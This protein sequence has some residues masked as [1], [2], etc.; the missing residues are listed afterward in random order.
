MRDVWFD[1]GGV[2]CAAWHF[3]G[4]G[5]AFAAER[6]RPCVVMAHGI[7][8]TRD[9]GLRPFAERF[10]AAGL[11]AFVFDYRHFGDSGGEPRQ[12]VSVRR[13]HADYH[14]AIAH[15]RGLDGV[16]PDRIV[17]WGSSYAGGHVIAVAADD[18]RLAAAVSQVPA[19]DGLAALGELLRYAG[20]GQL[21]R[22]TAHGIRDAAG[23][24]LGRAPHTLPLVGPPGSLAAMT[25]EDAE[26]GYKAIVGPTWRNEIGARALLEVGLN[27]PL[28]R[29]PDVRCPL[30]VQIAITDTVAPPAAAEKAA[31]RAPR[32][33]VRHYPLGHFDVYTG[34][35]FERVVTD[36]VAFLTRHLGAPRVLAG[37]NGSGRARG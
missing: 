22:V 28:R 4:E 12:L 20:P 1:S 11:D 34:D 23:A 25:T 27:R 6:G 19:A 9:S 31:A 13:Q 32:G 5:A 21:L 30:L 33:E 2:R 15:A 36:Q 18:D 35:G 3:E 37:A 26:A 16:D 10:A 24:L 8:G 17:V 29:A 14:A 7:G